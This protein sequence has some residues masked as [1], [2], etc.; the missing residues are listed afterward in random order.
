MDK[1]KK[2]A[3]SSATHCIETHCNASLQ[4][5]A[6][7]HPNPSP[8]VILNEVKD[9][10][11]GDQ[12]RFRNSQRRDSSSLRSSEWHFYFFLQLTKISIAVLG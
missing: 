9:L 8:A 7:Y 11:F 10:A 4:E 6:G 3:L 2:K 5:P 12:D 1:N